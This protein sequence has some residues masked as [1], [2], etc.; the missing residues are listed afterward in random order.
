MTVARKL[1]GS[2][3][4]A[5]LGTSGHH[6]G[7]N[8]RPDAGG[9]V[10]GGGYV[11]YGVVWTQQTVPEAMLAAAAGG[12]VSTVQVTGVGDDKDVALDVVADLQ[13][14]VEGWAPATLG[15]RPVVQVRPVLSDGPRR[16]PDDRTVWFGWFQIQIETWG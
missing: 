2:E 5:R 15:G 16:D 3:L 12:Q 11:P 9:R 13:A 14:T 7:V 10:D 6:V 4:Q 1:L 8:G